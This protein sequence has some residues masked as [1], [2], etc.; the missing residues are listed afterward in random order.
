MIVIGGQQEDKYNEFVYELDLTTNEWKKQCQFTKQGLSPRSDFT[1][2]LYNDKLY[3]FGG[4][5]DDIKY[6]Q[7][8]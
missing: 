2:N 6:N 8:W 1:L 4:K 5:N 3:I 7:L